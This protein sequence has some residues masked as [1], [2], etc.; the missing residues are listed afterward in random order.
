[1]K[2]AQRLT[3]MERPTNREYRSLN[4]YVLAEEPLRFAERGFVRMKDDLVSLRKDR[5]AWL[6]GALAN[7]LP[8]PFLKPVWVSCFQNPSIMSR[9]S[10]TAAEILSHRG[11]QL[12]FYILQ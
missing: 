3:A 10:L 11:I 2:Q 8:K 5:P 4:N 6:D 12:I 9:M 7:N 1:M